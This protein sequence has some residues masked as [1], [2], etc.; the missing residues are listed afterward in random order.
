MTPSERTITPVLIDASLP[1]PSPERMAAVA[2]LTRAITSVELG[3]GEVW[4]SKSGPGSRITA[5]IFRNIMVKL[6]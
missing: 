3:G 5:A 4:E 6:F 1:T 2:W